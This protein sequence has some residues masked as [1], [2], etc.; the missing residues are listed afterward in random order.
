[1][2]TRRNQIIIAVLLVALIVGA[3]LIPHAPNFAPVA[4][5][6]LFAGVYL[7]K[8]WAILLPISG[9]MISDMFLTNYGMTMRLAVY[10]SF[11]LVGLIGWMIAKKPKFAR[12]LAG[13]LAG[14][15]AFYL[16]TN[17]VIFY[18]EMYVQNFAGQ[19]QSYVNALPFFR[20]TLAGDLFYSGVLFGDYAPAKSFAAQR[21]SAAIVA[22]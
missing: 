17:L 20:W 4:A 10:G 2:E 11:M 7:R 9:L 13:T 22:K 8:S 14:S 19:M 5:A 12:I 6:A 15:V 3:R 18:P 16:I 1:M 21:K